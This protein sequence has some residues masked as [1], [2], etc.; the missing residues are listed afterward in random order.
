MP[1]AFK[2][3]VVAFATPERQW[4]WEVVLPESATVAQALEAARAAAGQVP[5]SWDD[6]PVG[7]FGQPCERSAV[8]ADGDRVELYRPLAQDPRESRR[9]RVARLRRH[10]G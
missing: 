5:A 9:A 3:C 2:R 4:L 8:P 6:A 10:K 7:I 1:E